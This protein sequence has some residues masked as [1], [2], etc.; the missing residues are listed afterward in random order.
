MPSSLRRS[1]STAP[2]AIHQPQPEAAGAPIDGDI[3]GLAHFE[4]RPDVRA[5]WMALHTRYG[6]AGMSSSSIPS[7]DKASSTA[8]MMVCGAAMLPACP[9]PFTPSGFD[10]VGAD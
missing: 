10:L 9:V 8:F 6:V 4:I 5:V 1:A 2:D 7:G 3:G